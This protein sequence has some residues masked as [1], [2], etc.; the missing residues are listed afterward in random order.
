MCAPAWPPHSQPDPLHLDAS[1]G[2]WEG[3]YAWIAANYA[4][5]QLGQNPKNTTG[6]VELGGAST[7]VPP[8]PGSVWDRRWYLWV[9]KNDPPTFYRG[10]QVTFVPDSLEAV[11]GGEVQVV[12]LAGVRYSLFTHSFLKYGQE[13][14][15]KELSRRLMLSGGWVASFKL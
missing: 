10:C 3:L 4:T 7:Q 11:P 1:A 15:G 8:P 5:G 6:I 13:A 9:G 12:E 2:V 14:A